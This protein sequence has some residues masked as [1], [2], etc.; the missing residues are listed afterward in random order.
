MVPA[1]LGILVTDLL[2]KYFAKVL[3]FQFTANMEEE[4]DL[5]EEGKAEWVGV[6][7]EFYEVFR[8]QMNFAKT[9][10]QTVKRE[11]EP[12]DEAC[13]KCG[14]P[15]IIKWG[16]RGRF[17]SCSGW[18]GCRNAKSISTDVVCPQCGK[19]KLVARRARSG[20]GRSCYGCSAYP[21]CTFITNRL[22]KTADQTAAQEAPNPDASAGN[23]NG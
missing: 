13:D 2:V 12:T 21:S 5:I 19:G 18:P 1:E 7:K 10:M 6:V 16:R 17:M 23:E 3:D 4:L 15:M 9:E 14:K 20:K 11:S 8:G 22:P